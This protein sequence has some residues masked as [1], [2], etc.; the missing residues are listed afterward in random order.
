MDEMFR[1]ID[2]YGTFFVIF[3][4]GGGFGYG[5]SQS[6]RVTEIALDLWR[7]GARDCIPFL[8]PPWSGPMK[9]ICFLTAAGFTY[10]DAQTRGTDAWLYGVTSFLIGFAAIYGWIGDKEKTDRWLPG[11]HAR[12]KIRR[13]QLKTLGQRDKSDALETLIEKFEERY[14]Q[15]RAPEPKQPMKGPFGS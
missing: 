4:A 5:V 11:M 13:G 12:M 3:I 14:P 6:I 8:T 1:Y 15:F 7:D 2:L 10:S 9:F